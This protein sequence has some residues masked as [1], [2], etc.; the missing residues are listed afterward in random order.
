MESTTANVV[1]QVANHIEDV[2][3]ATR[4]MGQ[5]SH[6]AAVG[7]FLT[8]TAFGF[9]FGFWRGYRYQRE[10]LR[11]EAY[12]EAEKDIE[13]IR[14]AYNQ[15]V[16]AAKAQDK[17]SVEDIVEEKGYSTA[18]AGRP[19]RPPVPVT[20]PTVY[21]DRTDNTTRSTGQFPRPRPKDKNDNWDFPRELAGRS[22][23]A[24]YVIHQDEFSE[25]ATDYR[26][27][28]LTFYGIDGVLADEDDRRIENPDDI[29]GLVNLTKFGHGTDDIDVVFI[30]NDKL[31]IE[32][33]IGRVNRSYEEEVMGLDS[34]G[35]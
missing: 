25:N 26:Q 14:E 28:V 2:A 23:E 7:W 20:E 21:T 9:G 16:A 32:A 30:R 5:I 15:K 35:S 10:K 27:V 13:K 17:P 3:N 33:E 18:E 29:V 22:R 1:G 8:G 4:E 12:A 19:L 6:G 24:P 31:E 11:A 34:S